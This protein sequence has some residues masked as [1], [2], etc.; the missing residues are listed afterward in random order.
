MRTTSGSQTITSARD[1]I[2]KPAVAEKLKLLAYLRPDVLVA[3]IK[4]A[5]MPLERVDLIE[6]ELALSEGLHAFHDVEQPAARFQR[7][8]PEE[9]RF[10]PFRENQLLCANDAVLHDMNLAGLRHLAEQ[11][12]RTNPAG[13]ARGR[14]QRLPLLDDTADEEVLR[15][16]EQVDDRER[17]EIVIHQKQVR[18]VVRG[19]AVAFRV[20]FPVENF[21]AEF[22]SL[23]LEFEF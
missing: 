10:L 9:K 8:I 2:Q 16:D 11:D 17:L 3:G 22:A 1:E 15:H 18:I 19:E 7:F 21:R 14:R 20:E 6:R 13:A 4:L 23:T 5:E 12:F